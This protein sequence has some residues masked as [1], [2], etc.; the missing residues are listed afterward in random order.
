MIG[1]SVFNIEVANWRLDNGKSPATMLQEKTARTPHTLRVG[2]GSAHHARSH[3]VRTNIPQVG[4]TLLSIWLLYVRKRKHSTAQQHRKI[5]KRKPKKLER[6]KKSP[7]AYIIIFCLIETPSTGQK[8][9]NIEQ[10]S[11]LSLVR[12][13]PLSRPPCFRFGPGKAFLTLCQ[14][15]PRRP[16]R[17]KPGAHHG[18]RSSAQQ[19]WCS[20]CVALS[21]NFSLVAKISTA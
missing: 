12:R 8:I 4:P 13:P 17:V 3:A 15:E 21:S 20:D 11:S 19:C 6:K 5:T 9:K 2:G 10:Q 16:P 14:S 7:S 1:Y 18:R